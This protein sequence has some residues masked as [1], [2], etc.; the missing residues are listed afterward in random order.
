MPGKYQPLVHG[1]GG[2]PTAPAY[3]SN[4]PADESEPLLLNEYPRRSAAPY[5]PPP[6][7]DISAV[8]VVGGDRAAADPEGEWRP[9]LGKHRRQRTGTN[10]LGVLLAF[11]SG[12]C[13]TL[14]SAAIRALRGLEP[15]ELLLVRAAVQ[16]VCTLPWALRSPGGALGPAGRRLLLQLQGVVG[17][18]TVMLLFFSFNRLPLGDATTI[19]FS[20]PMFVMILSFIFLREPC[21]FFRT[22]VVFLLLSG[23]VLISKPP[24]IFQ[25]MSH[26]EHRHYD[27]LGYACAVTAT[28]FTALNMVVMRKCKDVHFS[29]VVLQLSAWALLVAAALL[30]VTRPHLV[31]PR[32]WQQW[33][34][35]AAVSG[36]GLAGQVLVAR[37]LS[38][39][40][41]GRVSITRSM[42]IV[43]AFLLQVFAFGELPDWM[44]VLGAAFV[45]ACVV[46][47]GLEDKINYVASLVP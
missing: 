6:Y 45:L 7:Q 21:G 29:V 25:A 20:S 24:F 11:L 3:G 8:A 15:L 30:A 10:W 41:A 46:A 47:M 33:A 14:S 27:V 1:A 9:T 35:V 13:F 19:I 31:L 32:G 34:L 4:P 26:Q 2:L 17:G 12:T 38:L 44:S 28:L 16:V 37:A 22:T 43:L 42:D 36:F 40:D 18:I 5:Y 39:E 23:L